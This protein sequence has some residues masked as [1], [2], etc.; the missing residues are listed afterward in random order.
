MRQ[1]SCSYKKV[2]NLSVAELQEIVTLHQDVFNLTASFIISNLM[3]N[4]KILLYRH[5][6]SKRLIGTVA[7]RWLRKDCCIVCYSASVVIIKKFQGKGV[8]SH[9]QIVAFLLTIFKYPFAKKFAS[10]LISTSQ[11]LKWLTRFPKHWPNTRAKTPARILNLQRCIMQKIMAKENYYYKNGA[12]YSN[13]LIKNTQ[14]PTN[15]TQEKT[16]ISL[17]I[18]TQMF[19]F[20]KL[21][22]FTL[23]LIFLYKKRKTK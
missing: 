20:M 22:V 17:P 7:L 12:F 9:S 18:G 4:K 3:L 21:G 23:L 15:L 10:G 5:K 8:F 1:F 11:A 6:K 2:K 14:T 16:D 19:A 13:R